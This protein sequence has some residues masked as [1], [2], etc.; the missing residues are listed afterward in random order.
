MESAR[1]RESC[2]RSAGKKLSSG[3]QADAL[4]MRHLEM[5]SLPLFIPQKLPIHSD[6]YAITFRVWQ[7]FDIHCEINSILSFR[8]CSWFCSVGVG[9]SL[10]QILF[11][12]SLSEG[13]SLCLEC[14]RRLQPL[15]RVSKASRFTRGK[16]D[17]AR[18]TSRPSC[19]TMLAARRGRAVA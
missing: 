6:L 12:S 5:K 17:S 16:P 19:L 8:F 10:K 14:K 11:G 2:C 15:P 13:S 18:P 4:I 7:T 1:A 3:F 9:S